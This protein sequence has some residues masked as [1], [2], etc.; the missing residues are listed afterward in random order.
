MRNS[1]LSGELQQA[2]VPG[3]QDTQGPWGIFLWSFP[4]PGA[5]SKVHCKG[6]MDFYLE[7][8]VKAL[9]LMSAM[10]WVQLIKDKSPRNDM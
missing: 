7:Q 6:S 4:L 8:R 1:S 10:L 2:A 5:L 3:S 9:Y